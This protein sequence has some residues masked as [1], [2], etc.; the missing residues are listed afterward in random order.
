MMPDPLLPKA[1]ESQNAAP[2][3]SVPSQSPEL[4][5]APAELVPETITAAN[6]EPPPDSDG[7]GSWFSKYAFGTVYASLV[8]AVCL[9]LA[10]VGQRIA[11]S[12]LSF[13][14]SRARQATSAGKNP[15]SI[16]T[17]LQAQAEQILK[18]LASGDPAAAD[19]VL[20]QSD[21]WT[22][23]T[24]RT[25]NTDQLVTAAINLPDMHAREA[26]IQ[27][28]LALD[29]IARDETGL[30]TLKQ[31]VGNPRQ[32]P[33]VLWS[34]GALGNRGIDPVHVA[35]IIE[36][37]LTDPDPYV[38]AE[39]V[40]GLALLATDETVP[41][42]LDR[43]RNDPSPVVQEHSACDIAQSGMYTHPQRMRAAASLVGWLDDPLLTGQQRAWTFQ[44]LG[45]ITGARL[46]SDP[47]AWRDWWSQ[48][49]RR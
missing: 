39:A 6:R 1:S 21:A 43:F 35:K 23:N 24:Q 13:A 28:Q 27:A 30:N 31:A 4:A 14:A 15:H 12:V 46:G 25:Q 32:R 26:A 41:M 20:S 3:E 29:G 8:L 19:L 22:G 5:Q 40:D 45:D 18:R 33:W 2:G 7:Q 38:R 10:W 44:A 42:M 49:S 17:A 36:S 48:H 47:A 11:K 9:S 16:D 37:Y 34:L